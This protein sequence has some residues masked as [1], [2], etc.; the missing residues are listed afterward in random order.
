VV[1]LTRAVVSGDNIQVG[2]TSKVSGSA[3]TF[4]ASAAAAVGATSISV[5]SQNANA[6]YA[7]GTVVTDTSSGLGAPVE[8]WGIPSNNSL[9]NLFHNRFEMSRGYTHVSIMDFCSIPTIIANEVQDSY[10]TNIG[11]HWVTASTENG[12]ILPGYINSVGPIVDGPGAANTSLISSVIPSTFPGLQSFTPFRWTIEPPTTTETWAIGD[13]AT[14]TW[15]QLQ[16]N[17][18]NVGSN[19]N[20]NGAASGTT[21]LTLGNGMLT[22]DAAITLQS[23][24]TNSI[25]FNQS[26]VQHWMLYDGDSNLLIMR[27]MVNAWN[28]WVLY[29]GVGNN[30]QFAL[31]CV[32]LPAQAVTTSA[33]S[34]VKGAMYFDTTLNKLR[35]GGV[36]AWE[37]VTSA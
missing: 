5:T 9:P 19:L 4:V 14:N 2:H 21:R 12:L 34:Y 33:P 11:I 31:G 25:A 6:N 24:W 26:G 16:G 22:T 30:S 10:P 29:P 36:S 7:I 3:Q 8:F 1:A 13:P 20:L 32:F 15:L 17:A 37:T 35:I 27:D 28:V 18:F 23:P